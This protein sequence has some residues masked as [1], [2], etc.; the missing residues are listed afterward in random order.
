MS[1][2]YTFLFSPNICPASPTKPIC[3]LNPSPPNTIPSTIQFN[4][5][6]RD[7][8][9]PSVS[10]SISFPPINVEY[11]EQEFSSHGVT[12]TDLGEGCVAKMVLENGSVA[13]L[14]LPSGL[15]TSYK[16]K[17]WHGGTEEVLHTSV[18]E[19]EDGDAVIQGGVSLA[20]ACRSEE[21][22][23]SWS[24]TTWALH[25]VRGSSQDSIQVEIISRDPENMMEVKYNISIHE[26]TLKSEITVSN[27]RSSPVQL[28]GSVI[29]HLTVSTPDGTYAVG[30]EGSNFF[31][32]PPLRSEFSIL[33]PEFG[34]G[35]RTGANAFQLPWL[36][37]LLPAA[38]GA[39]DI[40]VNDTNEAE[41][42]ERETGAEME[43]EEKSDYKHLTEKMSRI[44]TSAPRNFT[45]IDRGRRNSVVVGRKGFNELY[46]YSPGSS[47]EWYGKYAY[48][49]VGQSAVL[50]PIIL[51]PANVWRGEQQLHNPNL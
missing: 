36:N 12:F 32:G 37:G 39:R 22:G 14:M 46:M 24:P 8:P 43:G 47:Y 13:T 20:L 23:F 3:A 45:I 41:S 27:S 5:N 38:W 2:A 9:L 15:I 17:M 40:I 34:Q 11:L 26:N 1:M 42:G 19:R 25:D 51:G 50:K 49:C 21:G 33:P 28:V 16:P 48:I 4:L 35:E 18:S 7:F 30:L 10:S 44:Y 31:N 6:R 29:S